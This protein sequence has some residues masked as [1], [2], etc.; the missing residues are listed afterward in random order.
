ME[1]KFLWLINF[2]IRPFLTVFSYSTFPFAI[3]GKKHIVHQ[4]HHFVFAKN[5]LHLYFPS[6]SSFAKTQN[7]KWK[8]GISISRNIKQTKGKSLQHFNH[9]LWIL[10]SPLPNEETLKR[11]INRPIP[12][13]KI[14]WLKFVYAER[15]AKWEREME[16]HT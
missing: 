11:Y 9:L 7:L 1:F 8:S 10:Q 2:S 12:R 13:H 4:S 6:T 14:G 5:H 15:R 3:R 16:N